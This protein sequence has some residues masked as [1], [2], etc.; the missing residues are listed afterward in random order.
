MQRRK[1]AFK[2]STVILSTLFALVVAGVFASN[3]ILKKVYDKVDKSD[4]YWNYN[5][6]LAKPY[7]Y[8]KIDGGNIT[9]IMFEQ[10]KHPSVRV[11][12]YW[13]GYQKD[14]SVRAYVKN[15]TLY[16]KFR[17]KYRNEG[18]KYWMGGEVLVRLFAPQLLTIEG[19][20]TNFEMQK[21]KQSSISISLY[22]KSKFEV[23]SYNHTFDTV[24]VTQRDSSEVEFE[25]SPELK[26]SHEMN[27]KYINA[28]ITGN[29]ILDVGHGY[30]DDIKLNIADS[31][32]IIL[33]G[34]TLKTAP[35]L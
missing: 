16:L 7:K 17:N 2:I 30:V 19:K 1:I 27:F 18:E 24:K 20:N 28:D 31:S 15:D 34:K 35:K 22:G 25:M 21:L 8:L 33:S 32:A 6:I 12:N 26:G 3:I 14:S 10:S 13:Q 29:S 9:Q 11:L 23:E 5:T 4:L